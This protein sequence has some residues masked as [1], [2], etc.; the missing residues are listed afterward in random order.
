MKPNHGR[1][2][3]KKG[4]CAK[5]DCCTSILAETKKASAD[6]P[7]LMPR[8]PPQNKLAFRHRNIETTNT[9]NL[10]KLKVEQFKKLYTRQYSHV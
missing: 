3:Q 4:K 9:Y 10:S 5:R 8:R 1:S 2:Q 6:G 7:K